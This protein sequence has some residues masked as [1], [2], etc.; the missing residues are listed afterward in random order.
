L[1]TLPR[2]GEIWWTELPDAGRRP[3]LVVTRDAGISVLKTLLVA[4]VTRTMRGIPTEVALGPEDGLAVECAASFD[5]LRL[6]PGYALTE[7]VGRLSPPKSY[8]LCRAYRAVA[9]C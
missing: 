3:A 4:P 6:V 1:V 5:N 2:Q 7:L 9:D 8:W